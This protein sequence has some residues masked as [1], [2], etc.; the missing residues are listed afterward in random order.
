MKLQPIKYKKKIVWKTGF[1]ILLIGFSVFIIGIPFQY[2]NR[3]SMSITDKMDPLQ[4][5]A[6]HVLNNMTDEQ[7]IGQLIMIGIEGSQW[8]NSEASRITEIPFGNIILFDRNM[9][10]PEQV[11][12]L[13]E[14]IQKTARDHGGIPAFI[15]LDQEGG[16]V[17]RMRDYMPVMPSAKIL[18]DRDPEETEKWAEKTGQ[19]LKKLGIQIDFAPVANLG[20]TYDRFYGKKPEHVIVYTEAAVR[21]Y[22]KA[23]II[24]TMKHFPG[25]GKVKTD[26]HIDRD[27]ITLT[28]KELD[29]QDAQTF[30]ELIKNTDPDQTWVMVSNVSY[31]A[32][33][34]ENPAC[35]SSVIMQSHIPHGMCGLKLYNPVPITPKKQS[36]PSRDVWVKRGLLISSSMKYRFMELFLCAADILKDIIS[37]IFL[38]RFFTVFAYTENIR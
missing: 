6:N 33:D 26:P 34:Q 1:V 23:G 31:P 22:T 25:I 4:E 35:F 2:A 37:S 38:H 7:K 15:A 9:D 13:T 20:L 24:S 18:G 3:T 5:K 30:R 27:I 28:W 19:E 21:G 10:N 29:N 12:K 32:I 11:K 8:D 17:L 16:Q 36:H 14:D